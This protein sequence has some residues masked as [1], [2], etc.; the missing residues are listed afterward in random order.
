MTIEDGFVR[1]VVNRNH[2]GAG[3]LEE[4]DIACRNILARATAVANRI[5][6]RLSEQS[7]NRSII[8]TTNS[9]DND[10]KNSKS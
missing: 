9:T 3:R 2:A 7:N 5:G 1:M 6:G 10:T 8:I 4:L